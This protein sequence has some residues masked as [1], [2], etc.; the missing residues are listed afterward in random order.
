MVHRM[1]IPI[2]FVA[3]VGVGCD[4]S[5]GQQTSAKHLSD[6][7]ATSSTNDPAT[8]SVTTINPSETSDGKNI[9]DVRQCLD[10][11]I[12]LKTELAPAND[13]DVGDG[14]IGSS[15]DMTH[16][17]FAVAA[18]AKSEQG[19]KDALRTFASAAK[20]GGDQG[21]TKSGTEGRYVWVVAGLKG[22]ATFAHALD[23]VIP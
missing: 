1:I 17:V 15:E 9:A 20:G 6:R 16:F 10:A 22:S 12:G 7:N 19:A 3:L 2:V 18:H 13:N 4:S 11:I 5:G 21:Q 23:C 8:D 14:V